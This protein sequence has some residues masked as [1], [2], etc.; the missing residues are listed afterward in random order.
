[1][2]AEQQTP[3]RR[4]AERHHGGHPHY[5]ARPLGA[6]GSPPPSGAGAGGGGPRGRMLGGGIDGNER[7]T[8]ATG[9]LLIALLAALGITILRIRPLISEHL[10]IGLLLI[11]PVALKLASTGYRFVRYYTANP[12]YR[13]RGAPPTA[14]RVMAPLVVLTS[15]AVLATGVALLAIGPGASGTLR[16]LHKA[17]FIA[18]IALMGLHVLVHL[19]DLQATFVS[20]RGERLEYNRLASGRAGRA[21]A[22]VGAI[23]AGAVVAIVL[24]PHFGEWS[25]FEAV[26]HHDH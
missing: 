18:W 22:L 23:V 24:I 5:E 19:P 2:T 9:V 4:G 6:G 15:V 10:F 20:R 1:M 8:A 3:A 16:G 7:L 26:R 13:K 17:S 14:L 25:H 11:P 21:I 12:A